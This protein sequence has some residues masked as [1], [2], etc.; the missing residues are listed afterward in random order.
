MNRIVEKELMDNPEQALAYAQADFESAHNDIVRQFTQ[1]FPDV[2]H[3]ESVIDLG[4]GPADITI[5]FA[6]Q[7]PS[8]QIDGV[9]GS[10][11]MLA[12]GK[13]RIVREGLEHRIKLF[14]YQL[15]NAGLEQKSYDALISNSL[16]HHLHDPAVLWETVKYIAKPKAYVYV[17]DLMRPASKACAKNLVRSYAGNEPKI[18]QRDFYNSLLA[19]FTPTEI[20]NQLQ[21]ARI[22]SLDIDVISDRHLIVYG[23]L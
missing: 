17:A 3:L 21:K 5:R 10:M 9:D 19:A 18:L 8:S 16:L 14:K 23:R 15:P 2:K 20:E 11:A 7:Y 1:L 12:H 13:D 22:S 6:R 4:C